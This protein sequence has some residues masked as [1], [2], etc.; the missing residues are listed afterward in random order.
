ME[1]KYLKNDTEISDEVKRVLTL[2]D[3][4]DRNAISL[5][6]VLDTIADANQKLNLTKKEYQ[7]HFKRLLKQKYQNPVVSL[8]DI[9]YDVK[10]LT[11]DFTADYYTN[12]S[13]KPITFSENDLGIYVKEDKTGCADGII[14]IL[15]NE[16]VT[17]YFDIF[18]NS[19]FLRENKKDI[20]SLNSDFLVAITPHPGEMSRLT[21]KSISEIQKNR[22]GTALDFAQ[23]YGVITVLKGA[24]TVIAMPSGKIYINTTGNA[25]MATAGCGDMLA[26]MIVAFL[27]NG[28]DIEKAVVSA[29][30][31][32]GAVGDK[33]AEELGIRGLLVSDMIEKLP[34]ILNFGE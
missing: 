22:I 14:K 5:Y 24:Y 30:C 32:H 16:I 13:L 27:A 33:A 19:S 9:P 23:S 3:N 7:N 11:M 26:G 8:H 31:L 2:E 12:R 10:E 20:R 28:T 17:C 6:S 4:Y 25:G 21:G 29:V 34:L 15:R 1:Y 18:S